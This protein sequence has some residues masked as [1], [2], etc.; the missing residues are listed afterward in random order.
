M[1]AK[2]ADEAK[3]N[4]FPVGFI[5]FVGSTGFP[6]KFIKKNIVDRYINSQLDFCFPFTKS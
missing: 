1:R 5:K 4:S 6:L 2:T 3:S